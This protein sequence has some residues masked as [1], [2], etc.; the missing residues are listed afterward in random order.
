MNGTLTDV[1]DLLVGHYT[2]PE[3]AT[4]C[5]VILTPQGA[6][7]G[8]AVRGAAPGSRE[9]ALLAPG[10][11]VRAV[12]AVLLTGGSA[13]GLAAADGVVRWLEERGHGFD[14]GV[15]K[16]PIVPAAVLFDL[17]LGSASARPGPREGYLA[18]EQASRG[19]VEEGNVG[20]GTGATVG[21]LLG[22]RYAMKG[23]LG[24]ASTRIGRGVTMGA[25]VAV[26]AL[27]DVVDPHTGRILAGTRRPDVDGF[28][29]TARAMRG[30]LGQTILGLMNTTLAVVATDA[31]LDKAELTMLAGMAHDGLARAVRPA[32]TMLDGDTI[33]AISTGNRQANLSALGAAATDV[34]AEAIVRAVQAARPLHGV[35][36]VTTPD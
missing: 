4:G 10:R 33:F 7:C 18:C 30:D 13:F 35:P 15:A 16:V 25:L 26:N 5:T 14:V 19:P 28:L 29:D 1:P 23:G 21:K 6:P 12:H 32:H 27:G 2:D 8:V 36:A 22:L 20:A 34:V 31:A 11:L 17:A 24:S 3:G 9:L